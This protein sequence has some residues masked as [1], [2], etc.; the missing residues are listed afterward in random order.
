MFSNPC[1]DAFR[2]EKETKRR[3]F[4]KK[5]KGNKTPRLKKTTTRQHQKKQTEKKIFKQHFKMN[6][7]CHIVTGA[8]TFF[9]LHLPVIGWWVTDERMIGGILL[10]SVPQSE[11]NTTF[12]FTP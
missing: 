6:I 12:L 5:S 4:I 10:S 9:F 8:V 2:D 3:E 7:C 11:V 1:W